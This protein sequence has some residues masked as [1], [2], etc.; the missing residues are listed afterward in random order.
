MEHV[1]NDVDASFHYDL[2][3]EDEVS[4]EE[5]ALPVVNAWEQAI[6]DKSR[7]F[8]FKESSS[9]NPIAEESDAATALTRCPTLPTTCYS[10]CT[11]VYCTCDKCNVCTCNSI[12]MLW[13]V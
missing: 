1:W 2:E 7:C 6:V 10:T 3:N 12:C 5:E 8:I 13:S 9:S 11:D 4:A